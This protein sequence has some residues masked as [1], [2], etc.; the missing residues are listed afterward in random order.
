MTEKW[1]KRKAKAVVPF[2][3]KAIKWSWSVDGVAP[4]AVVFSLYNSCQCGNLAQP[5]DGS[6]YLGPG[7]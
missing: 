7:L 4:D 1:E 3:T 2:N 6:T 5:V